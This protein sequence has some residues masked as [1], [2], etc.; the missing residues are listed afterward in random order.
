MAKMLAMLLLLS[1][2]LLT[3]LL[4]LGSLVGV[5]GAV[6]VDSA[7]PIVISAVGVAWAPAVIMVSAGSCIPAAAVGVLGVPPQGRVSAVA[8]VLTAVDVPYATCVSNVPELPGS[9]CC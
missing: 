4:L 5:A 9:C 7:V 2:L 3:S 6:S 1:L 8:A